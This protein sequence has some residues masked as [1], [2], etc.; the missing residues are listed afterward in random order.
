MGVE[1]HSA[2]V[3]ENIELTRR[4]FEAFN[5]GDIGEVLSRLTPDVEVYAD[6]ELP[7]SGTFHGHEGALLWFERWLEAWETFTVELEEIIPVGDNLVA[8]VIQHGRGRGSGVE[9]NMRSA[10]VLT[11]RDGKTTRL[12]LYPDKA[13]ALEVA[14]RLD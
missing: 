11:L 5:R 3:R 1:E 10:Y 9:V 6:P 8:C 12:H 14:R 2:E 7:N 13:T 4:S